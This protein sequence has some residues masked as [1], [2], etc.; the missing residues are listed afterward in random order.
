MDN[1]INKAVLEFEKSL[2]GGSYRRNAIKLFGS[3]YSILEIY[4]Y[5]YSQ[6]PNYNYILYIYIYFFYNILSSKTLLFQPK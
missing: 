1:Y 4:S 6:S 2:N 5:N 3:S